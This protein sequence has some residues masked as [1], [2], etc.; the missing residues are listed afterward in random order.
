[1]RLYSFVNMYLSPIQHGIQTAHVVSDLYEKY[2]NIDVKKHGAVA[3]DT[4]YDWG[5]N[6]KTIIVLNGGFSSNLDDIC[7]YISNQDVYPYVK[8][9]EGKDELCGAV[10]AVGIVLPEYVYMLG[11][12][13]YTPPHMV[14]KTD[15]D[16][17]EIISKYKLA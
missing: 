8:F 6:H 5:K 16:I 11:K 12:E 3:R 4:L 7:H 17:S 10:T 14:S 15:I 13:N 1:M 2:R 9:H